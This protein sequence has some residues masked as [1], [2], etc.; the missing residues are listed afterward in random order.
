MNRAA[1]V[2]L[3]WGLL[4]TTAL[5]SSPDTPL[6]VDTGTS[7]TSCTLPLA[8]G[9]C[10]VEWS[11]GAPMDVSDD[12]VHVNPHA[13]DVYLV[14]RPSVVPLV[15]P[16]LVS[17]VPD[18]A[19]T[20]DSASL[21]FEH[22]VFKL[23]VPAVGPVLSSLPAED[24]AR[25]WWTP[26]VIGV[27]TL[28]SDPFVNRLDSDHGL[29]NYTSATAPNATNFGSTDRKVQILVGGWCTA[30]R[31]E[32]A[33][34]RAACLA[35]G[36]DT[37]PPAYEGM[38]P[39]L[40]LG[41]AW[42]EITARTNGDALPATAQVPPPRAR[43][44]PGPAS[45]AGGFAAL[46][47]REASAPPLPASVPP[48]TGGPS[49][50]LSGPTDPRGPGLRQPQATTAVPRAASLP[51]AVVVA[52]AIAC[53][54]APLWRMYRRIH[55]RE[56]LDDDTRRALLE[57]VRAR[58]GIRP[59]ELA[60]A[61]CVSRTSVDYHA[62]RLESARLLA[63]RRVLGV[64]RLYEPGD[65]SPRGEALAIEETLRHPLAREIVLHLGR[66]SRASRADVRARVAAPARTVEWHVRRLVERGIVEEARD[67]RCVTLALASA[68]RGLAIACAVDA[69]ASPAPVAR[70][71]AE[72]ALAS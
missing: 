61:L 53:L 59:T 44:E 15:G 52:A 31:E 30:P 68:T 42:D 29:I 62:R 45:E 8:R 49:G 66:S 18:D 21:T 35:L 2:P 64:T 9:L 28:A 72:D 20:L 58:P 3:F 60:R 47:F 48:A 50:S 1:V 51:P 22:P 17:L 57:C 32:W 56:L 36:L 37:V 54:G 5:A 33:V 4:T 12:V 55:G 41:A 13:R 27:D 38:T 7:P 26:E 25:V 71:G 19:V 10:P 16:A 39:N 67:G 23:V 70:G 11:P 14:L 63:R 65:A 69:P 40:A 6:S 34:L 46:S 24:M 43:I